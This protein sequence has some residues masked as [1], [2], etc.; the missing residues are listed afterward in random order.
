MF[1][2]EGKYNLAQQLAHCATHT[3]AC[4]HAHTCFTSPSILGGRMLDRWMVL[5]SPEFSLT[6]MA[7]ALTTCI[8][9]EG[10]KGA[11][12]VRAAGHRDDVD[13]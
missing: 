1:D 2:W 13:R 9:C 3:S 4:T 12:R 6:T 8:T 7:S 10:Q 11:I 5:Y